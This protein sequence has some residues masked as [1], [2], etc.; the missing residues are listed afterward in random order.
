MKYE[1]KLKIRRVIFNH[2]SSSHVCIWLRYRCSFGS[3][4]I[5]KTYLMRP[6]WCEMSIS[7][8]FDAFVI[9]LLFTSNTITHNRQSRNRNN[10]PKHCTNIGFKI[11]CFFVLTCHSNSLNRTHRL[12]CHI[13]MHTHTFA[14][15]FG[16]I[17]C[18]PKMFKSV[19][20]SVDV[21]K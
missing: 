10:Q 7:G 9:S 17:L 11:C 6:A 5:A 20:F 12:K 19:N 2:F 21:K 8:S 15:D 1:S 4:F 18:P 16:E 14:M 3:E 13:H